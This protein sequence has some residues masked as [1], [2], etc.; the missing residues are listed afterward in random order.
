MACVTTATFASRFLSRAPAS[1]VRRAVAR[2]KPSPAS[3]ATS[4][5]SA[6]SRATALGATS[7]TRAF[8]AVSRTPTPF[9]PKKRAR[10][11]APRVPH[12]VEKASHTK[13]ATR[14]DT[15]SRDDTNRKSPAMSI[16]PVVLAHAADRYGGVI[17]DPKQLPDD[18]E[19]FTASLTKSIETWRNAGVRGVWLQIP[20]EQV[21][22]VA[23]A[24]KTGKFAYH[25]AEKTHVV[26]TNWLSEHEE[27]HLPPNAS[28]QV[29]IGA[30]V[31]NARGKVLLVQ[32]KRGP[33]ASAS[34]RDFWKL[35]TGLV[36]QGEDVPAAAIREVFE[37]TGVKCE[38]HSIL[39]IRHGHQAPFGK[40]DMFFLCALK[41]A[42]GLET[43]EIRIQ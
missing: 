13:H 9:L 42:D 40:S 16:R 24:V 14:E 29:G 34:R 1:V 17:I 36:E 28:H 41:I 26:M 33:A 32:E 38:F 18:P 10:S 37:E 12:A 3:T 20:I 23:P 21:Q 25:H 4:P 19:T 30:F 5:R 31:V 35:P 6:F 43:H 15:V 22:L 27:N 7:G 39:G 2:P 8:T 11:H